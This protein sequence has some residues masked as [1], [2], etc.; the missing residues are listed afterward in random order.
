MSGICLL[1]FSL[2]MVHLPG[3]GTG[4]RRVPLILTADVAPAME[5]LV[6]HREQCEVLKSNI[7][8]FAIPSSNGYVNGWQVLDKVARNASLSKPE[9]IHSTRLRKY[10]ATVTQVL[11]IFHNR[12]NLG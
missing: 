2:D 3:K 4:A 9:L 8:F 12:D 10:A 6:K 11:S 1:D 7:Y 5:A